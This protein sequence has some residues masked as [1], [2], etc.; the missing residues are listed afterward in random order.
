MLLGN[1]NSAYKAWLFEYITQIFPNSLVTDSSG[2]SPDHEQY[3]YPNYWFFLKIQTFK[4]ID[5]AV[6][7]WTSYKFPNQIS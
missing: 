2:F 3:L 7:T 5:A 4:R 1:M 6:E